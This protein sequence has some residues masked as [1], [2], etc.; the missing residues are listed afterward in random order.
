MNNVVQVDRG[1]GK[2]K[3]SWFERTKLFEGRIQ[4]RYETD[5]FLIK[6]AMVG[7][8]LI[9]AL[10]L[11]HEIFMEEWR[12]VTAEHRLDVDEYDFAGD[13]LLIIHKSSNEV[14]GAY[15]L[16]SSR[17]TAEFY[18]QN[19]FEMDCFLKWPGIKLEL[20][21]ACI[22][23][24]HRNGNAIDLLWKGLA[25]YIKISRARYLFGCASV[26]DTRPEEVAKLM[27]FIDAQGGWNL[28]H[29]IWPTR[30]Y[31]M[32]GFST[33]QVEPM[34]PSEAKRFLPALLRTYLHA[35]A[36]VFG[37][38]ALDSDFACVDLFTVL[39]IQRMNPRFGERYFDGATGE[40]K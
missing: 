35:G 37:Y 1:F 16:L 4:I 15:R 29:Q 22:R 26:K 27:R 34:L 3:V 6:T 20:G 31:R 7:R 30:K 25:S 12:G 32:L 24:D 39:D 14:I 2:T 18:S 9:K 28:E 40:T 19:E 10:E 21:R 33:H 8:E 23:A 17:F 38:P 36:Q 5:E 11:R 13:H